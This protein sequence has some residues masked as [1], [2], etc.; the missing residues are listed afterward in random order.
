MKKKL[1][2]LLLV[3]AIMVTSV[4]MGFGA[5]GAFAAGSQDVGVSFSVQNKQ[6]TGSSAS[7]NLVA[8]VG[9]GYKVRIKSVTTAVVNS[10]L[11]TASVSVSYTANS[12]VLTNNGTMAVNISGVGSNA[13][14]AIRYVI[15]YDILD[16]SNNAIWTDKV[17]YAYGVVSQNTAVS[18]GVGSNTAIST[19][20]VIKEIGNWAAAKDVNVTF[21]YINVPNTAYVQS[22]SG[23]YKY[24]TQTYNPSSLSSGGSDSTG[25]VTISNQTSSVTVSKASSFNYSHASKKS[26]S[27]SAETEWLSWS[28]P[29]TS[30]Y[31]SFN[32]TVDAGNADG[33]G[34]VAIYYLNA[35]DKT[36][37][38]T[39]L[40][41]C[42]NLQADNYTADSWNALV[43]A[44]DKAAQVAYAV[45]GANEGY[46][47]ACQNGASVAS[48]VNDAKSKL[49]EVGANYDAAW[50]AYWYFYGNTEYKPEYTGL[51]N[52]MVSVTTYEANATATGSEVVKYYTE[53]S[54]QAV[55]DYANTV[56]MSLK[57]YNQHIVDGYEANIKA[58]SNQLV[59]AGAVYTY[60]DIAIKEYNETDGS[61]YTEG[62][63]ASYTNAVN[64]A[65][66]VSRTLTVDSQNA[67]NNALTSVFQAKHK[68]VKLP[69]DFT[70]LSPAL[71]SAAQIVKEYN[72]NKLLTSMEGF[73]DIWP[74]F[75]ERYAAA[76]AVK[77]YTKDQQTEV[78]A[79]TDDLIKVINS[80]ARYRILD[81]TELLAA[82]TQNAEYA[83]EYYVEDSYNTWN[84][85]K[86][87]G[88]SF[89]LKAQATY[90]GSDR[91][92]YEN[93]DEMVRLTSAIQN[94]Y[95]NLE[96]I[97]ADFTELNDAVSRIPS[98]DV[99]ALYED[100]YV[101]AIKSI[102]AT[103][104]YGAT[105]DEQD[106]VK[107]ITKNLNAAL[108]E[109]TPAH[110]K[111]ADYADVDKAIAEAGAIN[112]SIV[113][114]Y[115][116][117]TDAINAVD[118]NKKI[119]EQADVDAMAAAIR[120]AI[121][122]LE[123]ILADYTDVNKAIEEANAVENKDWYANYYKVTEAIEAV[124]R[125][126]NVLEQ[127]DV[128]AM[129]AA[130]REAIANLKLADADYSGIREAIAAYNAKAPLSD[131][132][133]GTVDAVDTA[134]ANVVYG[135]KAD[136]QY[137]VDAWEAE[138][139][140]AIEA[141]K[142]LPADYSRLNATIAY[143][144]SL[145]STKYSNY[146]LVTDAI[147]AVDWELNCRQ[148]AEMLAQITAINDAV[149]ALE[150]LPADYT[151]VDEEI[152][153]ARY[154]YNN[155]AFP[156]TQESIDAVEAVIAS[157]DRTLKVD[158]QNDVNAY[159][160]QIKIAV[161]QLT[162]VRADYNSL[163]EVKAQYD[164]LQR[165][166]YA[167]LSAVDAY[168]AKIDWNK[169]IDKQ[170]EVDTYAEELAEMLKNLEYAPAD[171][172]AVDN[173]ITIFNAINRD[174]YEPFDVA[175]VEQVINSVETGLKKN[176]QERVNEMAQAIND[177]IAEL[178][179]KMKKADL[180]GLLSAVEQA[181]AKIDEMIATGYAIEQESY[182]TLD[183]Y[184]TR[185]KDFD[186]DTTI[187]KQGEVDETTANILEAAANLEFVFTKILDGSGLIIEDGYIYGFEE[188]STSADARALI[189][190]VGAAELKIIETKNGFGTGTMIQFI[191]TK[192]GSVIE[193]YTV[194][195]FGDATGD[196][197]IDMFDVSYVAEL[198]NEGG[199]PSDMI[200]RVLDVAKDNTIDIVD[201]SMLINLANMEATLS[202]DGTMKKY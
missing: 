201:V 165:D 143:A 133:P 55:I 11:G 152:E 128:D 140:A 79:A 77:E 24:Q 116:I 78:N 23:S 107:E 149:A 94:A 17:N 157:I 160:T 40:E 16:S 64:N 113:T 178:R 14:T 136:E 192:D 180:K 137:K 46:K 10:S 50:D 91:K 8:T 69:A 183:T 60:L 71:A 134:I 92:T 189:K 111:S 99:L 104:N 95:E 7:T 120:E 12:T 173:A 73:S 58:L 124:D 102:V 168:V 166:L 158:R 30:G 66:A 33:S 108:A 67:V 106:K 138:I 126:K 81:T 82:V 114:N 131:F 130:I 15:T 86:L 188:G 163:D 105:F 48:A 144:Q 193:T 101:N 181:N 39:A 115:S 90:T 159:I 117:V 31:H 27:Y 141:M 162:Y 74:I 36:A 123:Y 26:T 45:Q 110:Y 21:K 9:N 182:L 13:N 112:Q 100:T 129:A 187:D 93:Y 186:A 85:L 18:G 167:S 191:S 52:K 35:N 121:A 119:V 172:T 80:L 171:Y 185:A 5:I 1:L 62:S 202:Q 83:K 164:A 155:G 142:L 151:K 29:T 6:A 98:D 150:L 63:W 19:S 122:N 54:I 145:D 156:Y 118:R 20:A 84:T 109:L 139:E 170:D 41:D 70:Q 147:N 72:N 146:N 53:A 169:T 22:T 196:A 154:A 42:A 190:F 125:T 194:L 43:S 68:L 200:L 197:V 25:S 56:D 89:Y 184:L 2:S 179:T 75:E 76:D 148:N 32:Y 96:K 161:A 103:I 177:A 51:Q 34:S 88:R 57:R 174:Y 37:A 4:S 47:F 61:I 198:A 195:V 153:A 28:I 97:K 59:V 199:H 3:I 176:E 65:K 49:V 127:A 132:E 44:M 135:L 87:E 38:T 175:M